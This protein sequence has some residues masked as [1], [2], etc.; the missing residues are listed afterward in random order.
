MSLCISSSKTKHLVF[1][2]PALLSLPCILLVLPDLSTFPCSPSLASLLLLS[3]HLS[4]SH[5]QSPPLQLTIF[6]L[7]HLSI[8]AEAP[9]LFSLISVCKE[10]ERVLANRTPCRDTSAWA[11]LSGN[12]AFF[13]CL[14]FL[15]APV[16]ASSPSPS[17]DNLGFTFLQ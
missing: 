12:H 17:S 8:L 11:S 13:F 14:C 16:P 7:R 10:A 15:K 9:C 3:L 4:Q 5:P 6:T 1:F 2:S